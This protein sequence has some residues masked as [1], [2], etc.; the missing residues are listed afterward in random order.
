M[1]TQRIPHDIKDDLIKQ[2]ISLFDWCTLEFEK[3]IDFGIQL[4]KTKDDKSTKYVFMAIHPDGTFDI[5]EQIYDP[6]EPCLLYTSP[7]PRD[8]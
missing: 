8:S 6:F 7:S 5:S 4:T 1:Q 2:K 3:N